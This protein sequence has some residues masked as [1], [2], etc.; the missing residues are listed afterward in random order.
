MAAEAHY[1]WLQALPDDHPRKRRRV[2]RELAFVMRSRLAR[3]LDV[4]L[5]DEVDSLAAR[6]FGGELEM[7]DAVE[8]LRKRLRSS[9]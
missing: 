6:V 2:S 1:D 5:R 7:W 9:L 3:L 8:L 4:M